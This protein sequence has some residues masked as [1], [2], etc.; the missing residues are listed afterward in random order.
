MIWFQNSHWDPGD[1]ANID[2]SSTDA[3]DAVSQVVNTIVGKYFYSHIAF[4]SLA[5]NPHFIVMD[6]DGIPVSIV[7]QAITD[8]V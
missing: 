6:Y 7:A 1:S 2:H 8:C 3:K 4:S 5:K